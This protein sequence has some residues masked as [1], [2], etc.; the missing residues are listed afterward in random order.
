[1][2]SAPGTNFQPSPLSQFAGM[3]TGIGGILRG[4]A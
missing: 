4:L 1:V 3:A 2:S